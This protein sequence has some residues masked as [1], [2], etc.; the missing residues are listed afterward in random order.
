LKAEEDR[1]L[2]DTW[3]ECELFRRNCLVR[4]GLDVVSSTRATRSSKEEWDH[5][6]SIVQAAQELNVISQYD[7]TELLELFESEQISR[8]LS[9]ALHTTEPSDYPRV[10]LI[11]SIHNKLLESIE[12]GPFRGFLLDNGYRLML[13]RIIGRIT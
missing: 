11:T 3:I 4:E 1:A 6:K 2:L 7:F 9:I 13:G 10:E 12:G 8:R 5:L